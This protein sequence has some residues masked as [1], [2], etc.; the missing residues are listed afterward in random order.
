MTFLSL[1]QVPRCSTFRQTCARTRRCVMEQT[2]MGSS[3][4]QDN[5]LRAEKMKIHSYSVMQLGSDTNL[6]VYI[7]VAGRVGCRDSRLLSA[8]VLFF[9]APN[10]AYSLVLAHA[11]LSPMM[12]SV[13]HLPPLL[14]SRH[15]DL[16]WKSIKATRE[17]HFVDEERLAIIQA[18]RRNNS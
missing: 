1:L 3:V 16:D 12:P 15:A 14:Q 10:M 5:I 9:L 7:R 6:F 8:T 11:R 4:S 18:E 13:T 17:R 2:A